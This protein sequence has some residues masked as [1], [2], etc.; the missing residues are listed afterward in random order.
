MTI[1]CLLI[2]YA[3]SSNVLNLIKELYGQGVVRFY[4]AIDGPRDMEIERIQNELVENLEKLH[5]EIN[6]SILV[7]RRNEN[8]GIA[9][10]VISAI[11][12]FFSFEEFGMIIEDDLKVS[13]DFTRFLRM[14]FENPDARIAMISG[15][16]F[17]SDPKASLN[18]RYPATWGWATWKNTWYDIRS[19]IVEK[20]EIKLRL[21]L[22]PDY[23][24]WLLGA[25]RVLSRKIDTW[26][27]PLALYMKN[28]LKFSLLPP[29]NL[30]SNLGSDDYASHTIQ[31]SFPIGVPLE[32]FKDYSITLNKSVSQNY[33]RKLRKFVYRVK[34]RHRFLALH[35]L[36]SFIELQINGNLLRER[37]EEVALP[38]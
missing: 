9:V 32:T 18:S 33:D 22:A 35:M 7:W 37:L 34:F 30:V 23:Q 31:N 1:P 17:F 16:R 25:L 27:I 26:D 12:W 38:N 4:V 28:R 11:D 36:I 3:R 14:N 20:P 13:R 10:S 15:N 6:A 19:A 5:S 21:L 29:V 8:L 2:T 24:Y